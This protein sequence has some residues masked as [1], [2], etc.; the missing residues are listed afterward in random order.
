M[1]VKISKYETI[2]VLPATKTDVDEYGR[3]GQTY[4]EIISGLLRKSKKLD[5]LEVLKK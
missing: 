4:D 5:K 2:P 3:K 1:S